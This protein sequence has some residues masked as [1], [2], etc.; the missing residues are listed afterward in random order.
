MESKP[1]GPSFHIPSRE[2]LKRFEEKNT[3]VSKTSESSVKP[4][5]PS[6]I[7]VKTPAGKSDISFDIPT[8]EE[9]SKRFEKKD[10]GF[11]GISPEE[12]SQ[13][14]SCIK[15]EDSFCDSSSPFSEC[16]SGIPQA[17]LSVFESRF[18]STMEKSTLSENIK[19]VI[20][21]VFE[22][23]ATKINKRGFEERNNFHNVILLSKFS[24]IEEYYK[25][26]KNISSFSLILMVE[27]YH[28]TIFRTK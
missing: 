7:A 12:K 15:P 18:L 23:L 5:E 10:E 6:E 21:N 27:C 9:H 13:I 8:K 25:E 1:T 11:S 2:D 22:P 3:E 17:K 20:L 16:Y 24:I 26:K 4:V 14:K 19:I 28:K